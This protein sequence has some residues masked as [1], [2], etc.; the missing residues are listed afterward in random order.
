MTDQREGPAGDQRGPDNHCNRENFNSIVERNE[1]PKKPGSPDSS[2]S[3]SVEGALLLDEL[4]A[5]FRRHLSLP[6]GAPDAMALWAM[7]AWCH[8]A[9]QHSPRLALQSP[10]P[11]CGKTTAIRI[12]KELV[13]IPLATSDITAAGI[14][15]TVAKDAGRTIIIDE[16]DT[17]INEDRSM[18]R[19]LNSGHQRATASSVRCHPK[20]HHPEEYPTWAPFILAGIGQFPAS[21][22]K[23][24]IV[25]PMP[26]AKPDENLEPI[27][28]A[29]KLVLGQLKQRIETWA[30]RNMPKL[31][32][33][34]PD[35]AGFHNRLADNWRP[36]F[37]I[38]DAIGG[39]WP[40][41][42]RRA[43]KVLTGEIEPSEPLRILSM[44]WQIVK[45]NAAD[46][47]ASEDLFAAL[48]ACGESDSSLE[49]VFVP[50][51][52]KLAEYLRPF[53]IRPKKLRFDEKSLQG[54]ERKDFEDVAARYITDSTPVEDGDSA[55]ADY[56]EQTE[57]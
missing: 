44:C 8:D 21:L 25:V 51:K 26:R 42:A 3:Q 39:E 6:E 15:R 4:S 17:V 14:F 13:P 43:A 18:L 31:R 53:G 38:A 28:E 50:S 47:I 55:H 45:S 16:L 22:Q 41:R 48:Q 11:R 2:V 54:Y 12:L 35:M 56:P 10:L 24:S 46:R 52:R 30:Q 7:F 37:A 36:L 20:T 29:A 23:R 49:E 19:V 34:Y 33:A 9:F 5:C 32:G 1:Q 27:S 40:E 57:Q